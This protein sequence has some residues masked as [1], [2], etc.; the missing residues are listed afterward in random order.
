MLG[1][2][3][4]IPSSSAVSPGFSIS[5]VVAPI[6]DKI[7]NTMLP[8]IKILLGNGNEDKKYNILCIN[9]VTNL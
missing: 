3:G 6:T 1:K 5:N 2:F 4:T 8:T 7:P 9:Y